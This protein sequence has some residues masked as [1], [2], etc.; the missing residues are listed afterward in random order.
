MTCSGFG[1][2]RVSERLFTLD[3]FVAQSPYLVHIKAP[4]PQLPQEYRQ[5]SYMID[6]QIRSDFV[7]S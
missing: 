6:R 1:P 4:A 3:L 5:L 2:M 7:D